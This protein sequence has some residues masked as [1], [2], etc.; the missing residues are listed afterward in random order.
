MGQRLSEPQ[1][2]LDLLQRARRPDH[3]GRSR[4][5]QDDLSQVPGPAPGGGRGGRRWGSRRALP[6]LLPLSAYANALARADVRLDDFIARLLSTTWAWTCPLVPMLD[7]ALDQGGAL[8]LL[9]GL[10]EVK[11][12]GLRQPGRAS[13]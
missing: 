1:P 3:P 4:R 11:E 13:G 2:V 8:V 12:L 5:G 7:E 6:V 9:D 10:D